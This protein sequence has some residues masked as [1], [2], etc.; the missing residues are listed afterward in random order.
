[1][2]HLAIMNPRR[3]LIPKILSW[4]KTI[5]SRWYM[6]KIAPRGR[7][8][9]WDTVY[10]KD[11]GKA[12]TASATVDK[13]LQFDHFTE[14]QL[15]DIIFTYGWPWGIDF[16]SS[17]PEAYEWAKPKKYCILI[18]LKDPK[19]ITPFSIDKSWYGNACAWITIP[20]IS[21]LIA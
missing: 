11:A 16:H 13:I 3:K 6:M 7:I 5:E 12:V 10:F 17:S 19:A 1:M 21:A 2:D 15:H 20:D 8:K 18:F 4:E 14:Q 9:S